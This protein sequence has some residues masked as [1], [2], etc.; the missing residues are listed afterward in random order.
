[1]S[2][3]C[4]KKIQD[5]SISTNDTDAFSNDFQLIEQASYTLL[6]FPKGDERI[7]AEWNGQNRPPNEESRLKRDISS[8]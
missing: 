4:C 2:I 5:S 3:S 6:P 1:M 8:S 7:H